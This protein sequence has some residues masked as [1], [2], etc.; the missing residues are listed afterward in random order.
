MADASVGKKFP[1]W[2][3]YQNG[4]MIQWLYDNHDNFET[5]L[6]MAWPSYVSWAPVSIDPLGGPTEGF[7]FVEKKVHL[8]K[9]KGGEL[10]KLKVLE[11]DPQRFAGW[12]GEFFMLFVPSDPRRRVQRKGLIRKQ[13]VTGLIMVPR[14]YSGR[15][16]SVSLGKRDVLRCQIV[17]QPARRSFL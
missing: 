4:S 12:W 8:Q 2:K 9:S 3:A 10:T 15:T 13:F 7:A 1:D 17:S 14:S 6:N 11:W 5:Y 16:N